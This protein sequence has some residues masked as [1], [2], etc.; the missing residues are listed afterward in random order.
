MKHR[1]G[2]TRACERRCRKGL[3]GMIPELEP[4]VL[5]G[6]EQP[7]QFPETGEC[8]GDGAELD[9]FGTGADDKRDTIL[10]QLS[11]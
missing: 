5:P 7:R 10:A 2:L 11:P 6:D 1:I 4:W 8:M 9:R 3:E